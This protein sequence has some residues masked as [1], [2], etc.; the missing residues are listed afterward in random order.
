[1][2]RIAYA[3]ILSITLTACSDTPPVPKESIATA[4]QP[5]DSLHAAAQDNDIPR[6]E[7]LWEADHP[8]DA[9]DETGRTPLHAAIQAQQPQAVQWLLKYKA[10]PYGATSPLDPP[11]SQAILIAA[12]TQGHTESRTTAFAIITLLI[13]HGV[14]P[15]THHNNTLSPIQ[16]AMAN[17]CEACIEHIREVSMSRAIVLTSGH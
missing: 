11:L 5:S 1:M 12:Q 14:N 16:L 15:A 3:I 6:L 10:D 2:K 13:Q 4:H 8:L 17:D 9:L 7:A